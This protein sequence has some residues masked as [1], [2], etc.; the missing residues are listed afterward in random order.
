VGAAEDIA[1]GHEGQS[2]AVF[3]HAVVIRTIV[4]DALSMPLD[5]MF[6]LDQSY[7]G[8]TILEWFDGQPFVRRVNAT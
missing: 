5:A 6:R 1:A 2:V 7:G 8:V 3:S 4:A